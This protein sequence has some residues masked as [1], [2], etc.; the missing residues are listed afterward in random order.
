MK[1]SSSNVLI[2]GGATG[3]GFAIA[4]RLVGLGNTVIICGRRED[5]LRGA[6]SRL[7]GIRVL[8]CDV[9]KEYEREALLSRISDELGGLDMLINNAGI[10][11]EVDFRKGMADIRAHDDEVDINLKSQIYM[12]ALAVPL[13]M[14]RQAAAIVNVSSGLGFVPM[15]KFPIYSA[16]KAAIHS[17]TLSLRQQLKGTGISVFEV[18]PP[19]LYDTELKGH[20]LEKA[21]WNMSASEM[22]E[23][24]ISGL[25][26]DVY[27]IGAGPSAKWLD[28]SRK[29][30]DAAFSSI[31]SR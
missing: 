17:L 21:D 23:A 20:P 22:A 16:T 28:A 11:R 1:I 19:T 7:K 15:A 27:E 18:V 2:T 31:N 13:L 29:D 8:K 26:N 10:Q 9:S 25:Q 24:V 3:L 5:R 30:L 14:K 12:T 6:E 4:Q